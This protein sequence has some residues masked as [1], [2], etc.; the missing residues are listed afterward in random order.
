MKSLM[1]WIA[2]AALILLAFAVMGCTGMIPSMPPH[3]A[4]AGYGPVSRSV[5]ASGTETWQ[6]TVSGTDSGSANYRSAKEEDTSSW[7]EEIR[8]SFPITVHYEKLDDG[9]HYGFQPVQNIPVSGS[10]S[11]IRHYSAGSSTDDTREEGSFSTAVFEGGI[12]PHDQGASIQA[13]G[14]VGGEEKIHQ[15]N[16]NYDETKPVS[17]KIRG[18]SYRCY[19]DGTGGSFDFH[20]DG[21]VYVLDC[22][23][24]KSDPTW[25]E[26]RHVRIV[27]D[28]EYVQGTPTTEKPLKGGW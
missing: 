18:G 4:P 14:E 3:P 22:T 25:T 11:K 1:P 7:N 20:R 2:G 10:Y 19:N 6:V 27:M 26:T 8:A 12:Y 17:G 15:D 5:G 21:A 9:D 28:P 16:P 24:Q 23:L 13:Y